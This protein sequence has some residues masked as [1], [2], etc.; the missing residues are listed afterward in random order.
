MKM[1]NLEYDL[2]ISVDYICWTDGLVVTDVELDFEKQQRTLLN[3]V[4]RK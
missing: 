2:H 1:T 3:S 4:I